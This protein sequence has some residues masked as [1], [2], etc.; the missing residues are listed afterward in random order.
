[1][2]TG[3]GAVFI[4]RARRTGKRSRLD[5]LSFVGR[6][7]VSPSEAYLALYNAVQ[8]GGWSVVLIKSVLSLLAG[9]TFAQ[10]YEGVEFWLDVFQ[11]AAV[12]EI[13]HC[14]L[15]L[16][17]SPIFTTLMQ[18]FSR[19]AVLWLVLHPVKESRDSIGVPMLLIAWSVT[20]VIRYSFYALNIFKCVPQILIWLRYTLFIILYPMGASGE[21][22]VVF[23]SLPFVKERNLFSFD[24]PN[25]LNMSFSFYWFLVI[26]MLNYIPGFPKMYFYMFG[27]RK[28]VLSTEPSKKQ[29]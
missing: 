7:M 12:L 14:A 16:V 23:R 10:T 27:Q 20:E 2:T 21:L 24:M 8:V 26:F 25:P 19:V 4:E 18:V 9:A 17:R 29:K 13:A 28:K 1:A 5:S 11:T 6:S 22:F 15:G 3:A